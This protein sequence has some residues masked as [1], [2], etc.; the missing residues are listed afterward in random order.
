MVFNAVVWMQRGSFFK[1]AG[2]ADQLSIDQATRRLARAAYLDFTCSTVGRRSS[3]FGNASTRTPAQKARALEYASDQ[4]N[5]V[6][7]GSAV[8][9]TDGSSLGNPG[10]AGAG[11]LIYVK[12]AKADPFDFYAPLGEGGNNL[13]ELWAIG[14]ALDQLCKLPRKEEPYALT[15]FTD[16]QFSINVIQGSATTKTHRRLVHCIRSK[17]DA[18][19]K[20]GFLSKLTLSWVPGHAGL[21]E[22]EHADFLANLGSEASAR[23]RG[24]IDMARCLDLR[25]FVPD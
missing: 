11:G 9:F 4:L 18:L 19:I 12:G 16:S 3:T 24:I 8:A 22:N 5:S 21:Q 17:R 23:G 25:V 10:P 15:I 6:S 20:G 7:R 14:M 2:P 1:T 13:A